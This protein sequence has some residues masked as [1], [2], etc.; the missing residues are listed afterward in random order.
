[1]FSE[2][3]KLSVRLRTVRS[4]RN[5]TIQP[6]SKNDEKYTAP[7]LIVIGVHSPEFSYEHDPE[8]V[9]RGRLKELQARFQQTQ[10]CMDGVGR[11]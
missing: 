8:K 2:T 5:L 7:G 10:E 4:V 3:E 1:M 6:M 9:T 11:R